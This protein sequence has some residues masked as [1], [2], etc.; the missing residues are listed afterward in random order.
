MKP[1]DFTYAI[2]LGVFA[3]S[4][5]TGCSVR[6]VPLDEPHEVVNEREGAV[7]AGYYPGGYGSPPPHYSYDA[8]HMSHYYGYADNRHY[9]G[10]ALDP[11]PNDSYTEGEVPLRRAPAQGSVQPTDSNRQSNRRTGQRE[12]NSFQ[13]LGNRGR[14]AASGERRS[15]G[16]ETQ[17]RLRQRRH[18]PD[19]ETKV[20]EDS[21]ARREKIRRRPAHR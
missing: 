4:V 11:N 13:Q 16:R 20:D 15:H 17:Q 9:G 8:W 10:Y 12:E 21:K 14:Q 19:R 5:L 18:Q 2:V 6:F 3:F 7:Y 1:R